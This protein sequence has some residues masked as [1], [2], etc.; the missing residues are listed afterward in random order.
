[1]G[2]NGERWNLSTHEAGA[3]RAVA[4]LSNAPVAHRWFTR[5][6]AHGRGAA[7]AYVWCA[8]LLALA[9][10]AFDVGCGGDDAPSLMRGKPASMP[11]SSVSPPPVAPSE[12][13]LAD[14]EA[15]AFLHEQC[16]GCHGPK[17]TGERDPVWPMPV[18]L[19]REWLEVTDETID[20]YESLLR[21]QLGTTRMFPSPMPPSPLD[22]AGADK[23]A[24]VIRWFEKKLP[25]TVMD[26]DA[27]Y[28][29]PARPKPDFSFKCQDDATLRT[30][31]G[32]LTR[33]ALE[34]EPSAAELDM[35]PDAQL[36]GAVTHEQRAVLVSKLGGE[37]KA[38]FSATGLYKLAT[39]IAAAGKIVTPFSAGSSMP[40]DT[41]A[42]GIA[43]DLEHE[44][45][46]QMLVSYD[47]FDYR[48]YFVTNTVMAT[49]RTAPLYGC[50]PVMGAAWQACNLQA[51]RSGYFTTLGFLNTNPQTF[52]STQ[53]NYGRV[54]AMYLTLVRE[55]LQRSGDPMGPAPPVPDC[56]DATDTR[57]MGAGPFPGAGT[58]AQL[59]MG[60][61]CQGCHLGRGLAAGSVLFRPFSTT[62]LV[63]DPATLGAP[64]TPDAASFVS[65]TGS[66]WSR[67]SG[68][69]GAV[70]VDGAFL[71]GLL[72]APPKACAAT[73]DP[74]G[75]LAPVSDVSQLA[76]TFM[77]DRNAVTRGFVRHAQHAFGSTELMTLEMAKLAIASDEAGRSRIGHLVEAYFMADSFACGTAQ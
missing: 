56:I 22:T 58:H 24:A 32:R 34:R 39:S 63:Y 38:E 59:E 47:T 35:Y 73:G 29:R 14:T 40:Q 50:T 1:M 16:V 18:S 17:P 68:A 66:A 36:D 27:R 60:A 26:A 72:T 11:A 77:A 20:V 7:V 5:N 8:F 13:V 64:N 2:R 74:S 53:N 57:L 31:F 65:A 67:P 12:T 61:A 52:L 75:P 15:L 43:D 6:P 76:A 30:F 9:S 51:P 3:S 55:N 33:A 62:G 46:Q 21:K 25:F 4:P 28:G 19:T 44:L 69:G 45:Y 48:Q 23:L 71:K 49:P 54:K 37:W 41:L 70:P 42:P 10:L